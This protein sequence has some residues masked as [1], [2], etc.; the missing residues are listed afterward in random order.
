M[1][2]SGRAVAVAAAVLLAVVVGGALVVYRLA[3]SGVDDPQSARC[4][5][6]AIMTDATRSLS[7]H[8]E[9]DVRFTCENAVLS[10]TLYLPGMSGRHPAVVWVHGAGKASRL[11]WGGDVLP[12]LVRAGVVVFSYDKRGVGGSQGTCCPGDTGHFNLLTADAVGAADHH[13]HRRAD[14]AHRAARLGRPRPRR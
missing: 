11:T 14:P 4:P 9:V 1:K 13:G 3:G 5:D 2:A 7:D 8:G 6:P 12:G 10:G